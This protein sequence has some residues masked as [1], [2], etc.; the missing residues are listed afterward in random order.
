MKYFVTGASGFIGNRLVN[1]LVKNGNAVIALVR[2]PENIPE[3]HIPGVEIIQGDLFD[4]EIIEESLKECDFVFHLAAFAN[5]WSKDKN[6]A[7]KIN[8]E[9]TKNILEF[10]LKHKIKRVVFTSSAAVLAPSETIEEVDE[11]TPL[12][13][14]YLTDYES[15]KLEAENICMEYVQKGL[16]V[17]IVNPSRVFGPGHLNK[18]NS[19][20][21]MIQKYIRG[22][23]RIIPGNGTQIGNYVLV[24]DVVNGH[25]LAM[26]KGIKGEKYILG[27]TNVS[28]T[29]FFNLLAKVSDKKFRM[30]HLPVYFIILISKFELFM[31]ENFG[32]KPLITPP[33]AIRYMQNRVLSSQ[34]AVTELGYIITPLSG[35]FEKTINWL[36]TNPE[37]K[38]DR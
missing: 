17:V 18:S 37:K 27:G 13:K 25:L 30:F 1:E 10:S 9:G 4:N 21:I 36:N 28:F 15:T 11:K 20:T 26:K 19:V 33:W 22:K 23:W 29:D 7:W 3:L 14:I 6:Y 35:S 16:D 12:P 31:A 2:Q 5:I 38:H 24:D 34:K 32:K 8:V